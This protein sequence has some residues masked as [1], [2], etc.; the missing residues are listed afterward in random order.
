MQKQLLT[1]WCVYIYVCGMKDT[2]N[3]MCIACRRSHT[4]PIAPSVVVTGQDQIACYCSLLSSVNVSHEHHQKHAEKNTLVCCI[5]N[6]EGGATQCSII[7]KNSRGLMS[8]RIL[9]PG[10]ATWLSVQ[11]GRGPIGKLRQ[12]TTLGLS[13][14]GAVY[15]SSRLVLHVTVQAWE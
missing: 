15:S 1:L 12:E 5:R 10:R 11:G 4:K 14:L 3:T 7:R 2:Y 9:E 6:Q 13:S 8:P